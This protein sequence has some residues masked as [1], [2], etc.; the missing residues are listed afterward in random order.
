MKNKQLI[1]EVKRF[2][3]IA[4]IKQE[5]RTPSYGGMYNIPDFE[6]ELDGKAF[7]AN[8]DVTYGFDWDSEDGIYN[9]EQDIEVKELGMGDIS[10]Y[11]YTP[12]TDQKVMSDIQQRLNTDPKLDREIEDLVDTWDAEPEVDDSYDERFDDLDE[13]DDYDMGTPSGDTDA[14]NIG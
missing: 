9:Y 14:M 13:E 3:E 4:G 12:V 7:I 11:E 2:Q 10:D 1:N 8:L 6:F 5:A